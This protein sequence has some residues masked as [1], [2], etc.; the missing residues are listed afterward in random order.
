MMIPLQY[1]RM[2]YLVLVFRDS[3]RSEFARGRIV[4]KSNFMPIQG[5]LS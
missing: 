4:G 5:M 3:H 2:D 1:G